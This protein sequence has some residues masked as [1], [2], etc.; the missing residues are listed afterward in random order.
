MDFSSEGYK[1]ATV[2]EM[3]DSGRVISDH[4][5]AGEGW[6]GFYENASGG[7][8][9]EG[10]QVLDLCQA[11]DIPTQKIQYYNFKKGKMSYKSLDTID[12]KIPKFITELENCEV[13]EL[14]AKIIDP[15][16][17]SIIFHA[18]FK[19]EG[20]C[21]DTIQQLEYSGNFTVWWEEEYFK[22]TEEADHG[23]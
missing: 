4:N 14:W 19:P 6:F 1:K 17:L 23:D 11:L 12:F 9:I 22:K 20:Y 5:H 3:H 2:I 10:Q 15:N 16:L 8:L 21:E 18:G 13:K 7:Y